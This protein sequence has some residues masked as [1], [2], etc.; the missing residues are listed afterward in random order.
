M[1]QEIDELMSSGGE[2]SCEDLRERLQEILEQN[3]DLNRIAEDI[4]ENTDSSPML[5]LF[6]L[7]GLLFIAAVGWGFVGFIIGLNEAE[8]L[9]LADRI[10]VGRQYFWFVFLSGLAA[11]GLY[12]IPGLNLVMLAFIPYN[13]ILNVADLGVSQTTQFLFW[14]IVIPFFLIGLWVGF[15]L[16]SE[17]RKWDL[18]RRDVQ[19]E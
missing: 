6:K 9:A 11:I 18:E 1:S 14:G 16:V 19:I 4:E 5:S 2:C 17:T 8:A 15:W 7:F 10:S 3:Q 13:K 12:A